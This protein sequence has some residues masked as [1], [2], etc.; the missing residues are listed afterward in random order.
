[1]SARRGRGLSL[2]C[3]QHRL[4]VPFFSSKKKKK[5]RRRR[6]RNQGVTLHYHFTRCGKQDAILSGT[7][8]LR[9][10]AQLSMVVN[11]SHSQV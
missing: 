6:R 4:S 11:G 9:G 1:M 5:R 3:A 8:Y 2:S 10:S 7:F